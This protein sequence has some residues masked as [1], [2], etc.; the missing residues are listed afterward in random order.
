VGANISLFGT[1]EGTTQPTGRNGRLA[2]GALTQLPLPTHSV[3]VRIAGV[4]AVV[5]YAGAA[6]GLVAGVVQINA[7]IPDGISIGPVPVEFLAEGIPSPKGA[8]VSVK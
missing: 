6:P 5:T 4:D 7:R 2:L 3:Q 8:T 1:G